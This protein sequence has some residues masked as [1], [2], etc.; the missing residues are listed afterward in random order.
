M[1][2]TLALAVR[3]CHWIGPVFLGLP[4]FGFVVSPAHLRMS[5]AVLIWGALSVLNVGICAYAQRRRD[6]AVLDTAMCISRVADRWGAECDTAEALR[7]VV[8]YRIHAD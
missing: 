4:L 8:G 7:R 3:Y 1:S 2:V 6:R 5:A